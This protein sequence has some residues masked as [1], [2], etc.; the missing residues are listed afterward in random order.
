MSRVAIIPTYRYAD[1]H[2]AID[3]LI[4]ALGFEKHAVH[5]APDG[6]VA[7]AQLT[8]RGQMIMLG[9]A[10]DDGFGAWQRPP[11]DGVNT[12][13]AYIVVDDP[14]AI[15]DRAVAAGAEVR[16]PIEDEDYGGRGFTVAD[17]EGVLWSFGSYDPFGSAES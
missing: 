1:A 9:T 6:S 3:W 13:S 12:C 7:H 5:E 2:A 16:M 14:D 8:F 15:Y 4:T 10:A 11:V 17:P